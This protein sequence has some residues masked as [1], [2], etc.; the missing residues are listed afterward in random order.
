MTS[1]FTMI[2]P[3]TSVAS[4]ADADCDD[5]EM[6]SR[7]A[8]TGRLGFVTRDRIEQERVEQGGRSGA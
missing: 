1:D 4:A 5:C 7:W 8:M 2:S 3:N 6:F